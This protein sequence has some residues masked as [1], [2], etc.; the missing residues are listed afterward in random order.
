MRRSMR[1]ASQQ[2]VKPKRTPISQALDEFQQ[3]DDIDRMM[4]KL[5]NGAIEME[6]GRP[7]MTTK[8]ET[9][10]VVS[11]LEGWLEYWAAVAKKRDIPYN[12]EPMQ[13]LKRRLDNGVHLTPDIIQGAKRVVAAQRAMFRAIP[14]QEISSDAVTTQIKL[15]M[16]DCGIITT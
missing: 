4:Q 2:P 6:Q 5:E 13:I 15:A 16:E 3:F 11:A 7:V 14:R 9:Y 1:K 10:D 12:D 8:G